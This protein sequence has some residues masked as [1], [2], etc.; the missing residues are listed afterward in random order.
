M[1]LLS[2]LFAALLLLQASLTAGRDAMCYVGGNTQYKNCPVC[3]PGGGWA[4]DNT[5]IS[6]VRILH[7]CDHK[8][9]TPVECAHQCVCN[10]GALKCRGWNKCQES[11][12][13][14]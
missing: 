2:V 4:A 6:N 13:T 10:D 9:L 3:G 1:K 14:K 12:V 8:E 5:Y 11:T 7:I